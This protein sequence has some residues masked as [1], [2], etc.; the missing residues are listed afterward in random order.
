MRLAV[1][2][3][4]VSG[5][6]CT[7]GCS[8]FVPRQQA[9]TILAGPLPG[10][11]AAMALYMTFRD[12]SP[13]WV[14]QFVVVLAIINGLNLLPL[15]F[16]DGGRLLNLIVYSRNAWI[17]TMMQLV[18]AG[19]FGF[20]AYWQ[21]NYLLAVLA[22][23]ML[24]GAP[25]VFRLGQM[26]ARLRREGLR[27][28]DT[29]AALQPIHGRMLF[30]ATYDVMGRASTPT[31]ANV[32]RQ[33]HDRVLVPPPGVLATV[34]FLLL[35]LAGWL[36]TIGTAGMILEDYLHISHKL[37]FVEQQPEYQWKREADQLKRRARRLRGP[38]K[39]DAERK[40]KQLDQQYQAWYDGVVRKEQQYLQAFFKD[41]QRAPQRDDDEKEDEVKEK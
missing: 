36:M 14:L 29:V 17:E 13:P 32:M 19:L 7:P 23:L 21:Q 20:L 37:E 30:A 34:G 28:P 9:V 16:A 33:L 41:P 40:A 39:D 3:L 31:L 38:A 27:M 4:V 2:L 15:G 8:L 5:I 12:D 1:V 26:I 25:M 24:L 11:A 10:L 22:V 35:Y 6:L 18:S